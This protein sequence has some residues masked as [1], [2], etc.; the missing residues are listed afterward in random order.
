MNTPPLSDRQKAIANSMQNQFS[1]PSQQSSNSS[2][3]PI[4]MDPNQ[5]QNMPMTSNYPLPQG[6]VLL[7]PGSNSN[8][9][10]MSSTQN[11]QAGPVNTP[12]P[13]TSQLPA[14]P[15]RVSGDY[16]FMSD[17]Q[18]NQRPGPVMQQAYGGMPDYGYAYGGAPHYAFAYGGYLPMGKYGYIPQYEQTM[19]G[20]Q[21]ADLA[22]DADPNGGYALSGTR[23]KQAMSGENIYG[24]TMGLLGLGENWALAPQMSALEKD[25]MDRSISHNMNSAV[26]GY[27]GNTKAIGMGAGSD[28]GGISDSPQ[29]FTKQGGMIYANG[30]A[31]QTGVPVDLTD[32]EIQA[33]MAAGGTVRYV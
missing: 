24:T 26:R 19:M 32:D 7:P 3:A 6:Q 20:A 13:T 22:N 16:D 2:N 12:A 5:M 18:N 25:V 14:I 4:N 11:P 28:F 23:K 29:G 9:D 31:Y 10:F 30:G 21:E 1:G 15:P 27:K 33:I 17:L 8:Y